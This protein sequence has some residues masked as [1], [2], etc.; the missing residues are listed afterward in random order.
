M[1]TKIRR[2]AL[3]GVLAVQ[4]VAAPALAYTF[5]DSLPD[6]WS[7]DYIDQV[8][9]AKIM[10]GTDKGLFYPYNGMTRAEAVTVIYRMKMGA[11]AAD[12]YGSET[13]FADVETNQWY[14]SAVQW[15]YD[16]GVTTGYT[17]DST[18]ED[19]TETSTSTDTTSTSTT[20]TTAKTTN[21]GPFDLV[22]REQFATMLWRLEEEPEADNVIS[23]YPD[24][25]DVSSW[26]K[27]AM[28]WANI[29]GILTGVGGEWLEPN[30]TLLREQGAKMLV[31]YL[32]KLRGK[33]YA[34]SA[35]AQG[36]RERVQYLRGT[37]GIGEDYRGS[38]V[39]G[40]KDWYHQAYIVMHDT[41][42]WGDAQSVIDWWDESGSGVAA[43]FIV[44]TDGSVMQCVPLSKI[45]HHAG[46][47]DPGHN[48]YYGI[49]EDGRD[50]MEGTTPINYYTDYAMNAWS[51]GIEMVHVG[52]Y[53]DGYP[54]AQLEA[55]DNLIAYLD[56]Y[57]GK[58]CTIIDHKMWRT[59]N[60]D[61][62]E[63]FQGYLENLNTLR[64]HNG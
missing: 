41:E 26:A 18:T 22:T 63:E 19:S 50:D 47:G 13:S 62:S 34:T 39:H 35:S 52:D 5:P 59:S 16:N 56:A 64:N 58:E 29:Q 25:S 15:A 28:N 40:E 23:G 27:T 61:C 24:A 31:V 8:S 32:D 45:T 9:E 42:G 11:T 46:Y 12:T 44:N 43:H 21:F 7:Y 20:T 6:T 3:A 48:D 14:T 17:D 1:L 54:E 57:Y 37:L 55:V 10:E 51:I 53:G 60:S 36:R 30:G 33:T 49:S 2:V 4:A 38:F